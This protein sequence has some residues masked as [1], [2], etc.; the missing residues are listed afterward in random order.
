[1]KVLQVKVIWEIEK[2][3][4]ITAYFPNYLQGTIDTTRVVDA[5]LCQKH[6]ARIILAVD[7]NSTETLAKSSTGKHN[8]ETPPLDFQPSK[9]KKNSENP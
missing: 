7:F 5:M 8:I 2:I 1:M 9:K 3:W 4:L 6:G